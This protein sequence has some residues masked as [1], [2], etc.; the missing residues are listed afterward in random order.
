MLRQRKKSGKNS[1]NCGLH[2]FILQH[3]KMQPFTSQLLTMCLSFLHK[4][5]LS[6]FKYYYPIP[7]NHLPGFCHPYDSN[8]EGITGFSE[9]NSTRI[10]NY[11]NFALK[12]AKSA[13]DQV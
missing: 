4:L 12:L 1:A 9:E 2:H 10:F 7:C 11:M 3:S 6:K 13:G 8:I 5:V